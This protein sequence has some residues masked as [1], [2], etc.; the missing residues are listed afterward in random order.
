MS[1]FEQMKISNLDIKKQ[2]YS[3]LN[4]RQRRLYSGELA[5]DLGH[6][7]IKVVSES[8]EI[9]PTTI[10]TGIKELK[11]SKELPPNRVRQEGGGRKKNLKKTQNYQNSLPK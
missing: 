2:F 6:G 8:L 5:L 7:G 1:N 3:T 10:R 4:E 11:S 9:D